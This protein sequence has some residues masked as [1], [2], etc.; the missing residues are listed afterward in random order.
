M[1][2]NV[3]TGNKGVFP[4]ELKNL[5]GNQSPNVQQVEN[6]ASQP[7]LQTELKPAEQNSKEGSTYIK[8]ES[9][10]DTN[11]ITG[12]FEVD[13]ISFREK[14]VE[15][16]YLTI[17]TATSGESGQRI[18]ASFYVNNEEDFNRFKDFISNLNWND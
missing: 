12:I 1:N 16:R 6:Q 18:N 15:D 14:G 2:E 4:G 5:T 13:L 11:E 17:S 10:S 9:K 3:N 7:N 8:L